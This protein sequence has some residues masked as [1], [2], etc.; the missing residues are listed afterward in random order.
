MFDDYPS[1][2]G[3]SIS[4]ESRVNGGEWVPVWV[5]AAG[6]NADIP[7][8]LKEI[9]IAVS[10]DTMEFAWT[11]NGD[12]YN[13]N[14]WY[15]DN[16]CI[17]PLP[18]PPPTALTATSI[19]TTSANLTWTPAGSETNWEYVY[20]VSPLAVPAG[21]GTA[22]IS[23]TVNPITG[24]S[25]GTKYQFY[26]RA[27]CGTGL[28][29]W[30]GPYSFNTLCSG[31]ANTLFPY[32]ENFN[33]A[34]VPPHCWSEIIANANFH[35]KASTSDPG[36]A[37]VEY[38]PAPASQDEWL[39]TPVMDFTNL[40]HPRLSFKWMMSY[41]WS[42]SPYNN[43]DL[44]CKIST[45]GGTSWIKIWS[46]TDEGTFT[47][48][49][50]KTKTLDLL[51]YAGQANVKFA[52]QYV[53]SDGAQALIDDV[54]IDAW[55]LPCLTPQNLD[56]N[57]VTSSGA[58]LAWV[59]GGSETNW[60]YVY[61][62]SP[63]ASPAGPGTATTSSNVNPISGLT[64]NTAYQY[65]ARATCGTDNS[66][67]AGPFTFTT[68]PY[69]FSVTGE[70]TGT[71][72]YNATNILTVGGTPNTFTIGSTGNVTLIAGVQI[73]LL[74][75]T[76]VENGGYLFG[77]ITQTNTYCGATRAP[78][79]AVKTGTDETPYNTDRLF[80]NLYPNPTTGN[81]ILEQKGENAYGTVKVEI[82]SM[83]GAKVLT[84]KMTGEKRHEFHFGEMPNGLYFVK[85]V[86]D[87]SVET[88]K[89]V[90]TR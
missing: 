5:H 85:V 71:E 70:V 68:L 69:N 40:A 66:A 18:C 7:A 4:L 20:G 10:G 83:N 43:Y 78:M 60:E 63:I 32:T 64:D 14:Y 30:A 45:D 33:D 21:S 9:N 90:K 17:T 29:S 44:N 12:H 16:V 2:S 39:V 72:C 42:V 88:I 35:W 79:V 80:F 22:T 27:N 86:A 73:R 36:W 49:E 82:F 38:D 3:V 87:D 58:N 52:W 55:P 8:E 84:E 13:I 15:V 50:A 89:V 51:A 48:Y 53:G 74:P 61:G 11:V 23:S 46:E 34:V 67:W 26:V 75:G 6:V 25:S 57:A 19:T 28:S 81:F 54:V 37:D 1:G 59:P 76:T 24:L 77:Y 41:Y 65:Y 56:A 47:T 31:T 62:L